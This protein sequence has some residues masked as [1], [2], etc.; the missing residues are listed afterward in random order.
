MSLPAYWI[1]NMIADLI[2]VYI[3]V[4][5]MVI[6]SRIFDVNYKG[7]WVLF[8]LL[9]LALVP[10]TYITSFL[11]KNDTSAQIVTLFLNFFV[12]AVMGVVVFFL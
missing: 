11:F 10:F 3:P 8:L 1:S 4:L 2:K 12:C 9:P 5:L 6:I 7:V